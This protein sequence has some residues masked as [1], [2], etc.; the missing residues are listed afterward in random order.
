MRPLTQRKKKGVL[1]IGG[2]EAGLGDTGRKYATHIWE[3]Q[4]LAGELSK[5]ISIFW[6]GP[7]EEFQ[8]VDRCVR[9]KSRPLRLKRAG[10]RKVVPDEMSVQREKDTCEAG[11]RPEV[12]QAWGG[13][14]TGCM[15]YLP[16]EQSKTVSPER[17][18]H[19]QLQRTLRP[20]IR[21]GFVLQPHG[22]WGEACKGNLAVL[23]FYADTYDII[24]K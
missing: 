18:G 16:G 11:R 8:G 10:E 12:R 22:H 2:P 19:G 21:S 14:D 13:L 1:P 15:I 17:W 5:R 7:E 3:T 6:G 23:I 24:Y 20:S 4:R 9:R